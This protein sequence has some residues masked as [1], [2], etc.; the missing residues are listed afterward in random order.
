V[1]QLDEFLL[2]LPEQHL[3]DELRVLRWMDDLAAR[4]DYPAEEFTWDAYQNSCI[5]L[6]LEY[7]LE[8]RTKADWAR[9]LDVVYQNYQVLIGKVK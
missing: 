5:D 3:L 8:I 1:I 6:Q 9:L 2:E 4:S 7:L